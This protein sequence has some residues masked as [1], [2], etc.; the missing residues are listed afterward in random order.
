MLPDTLENGAE[1]RPGL[2]WLAAGLV[3]VL[4]L[5]A[6]VVSMHRAGEKRHERASFDR[7]LALAVA[8]EASV[9]SAVSRVRDVAQYA[10][11]L[12]NSSLTPAAERQ[13]LYAAVSASA[14]QA[15]IVIDTALHRLTAAPVGQSKRLRSAQAATVVY[16][17]SWAA[18]F[19]RAAG[20]EDA[21]GSPPIDLVGQRQDASTAL[22][23][24]APDRQRASNAATALG[25]SAG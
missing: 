3:V 5:A 14:R 12:L 22:Q 8:G 23:K 17:S 10:E 11:P 2:R 9:E 15:Q 24:A 20:A 4:V 19:A 25:A 7:L 21:S 1:P 18:V 13:T 16:L 6:V